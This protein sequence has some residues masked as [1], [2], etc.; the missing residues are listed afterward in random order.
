MS[1]I[2]V[3]FSEVVIAANVKP[4]IVIMPSTLKKVGGWGHI[5]SG[6]SVSLCIRSFVTLS[7][8]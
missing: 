2:K 4:C 5:A 3:H 6:L 1:S 8:A 7:G